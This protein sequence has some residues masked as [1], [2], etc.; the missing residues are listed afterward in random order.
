MMEVRPLGTRAAG[1]RPAVLVAQTEHQFEELALLAAQLAYLGVP[2]E[3]VVPE[4]PRR[5]LMR[6]RPAVRRHRRTLGL[7]DETGR[8]AGRPFPAEEL[9]A[10]AGVVLVMNDWG[11][12]RGL[13]LEA[14]RLGIPTA[15][16]VEG[17]QDFEDVDTGRRRNPY[18][19]ADLVLCLGQYDHDALSGTDRV[20]VGSERLRRLWEREASP[21]PVVPQAAINANFSYG[22]QTE[23]R[24]TWVRGAL[25][26]A[27]EAGVVSVLTRHPADR[28]L[29]GASR[30]SDHSALEVLEESTV[31]VSRF[32][33]LV[34]ESLLLGVATVYHNPHGEGAATF[35]DPIGGFA[36]TRDIRELTEQLRT[37]PQSRSE[38]R[39]EASGFLRKH[40]LL[41]SD[42]RP[43]VLASREIEKL[44]GES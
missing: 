33:T 30:V 19:S 26:A 9:L 8:T 3:L 37:P 41:E 44:R 12:P 17:V 20:I 24:R 29:T 21:I 36:V 35:A 7:V 40:L 6:Y 31:L 14:Q 15:A 34:Y 27:N 38:I 11:V 42:E 1:P 23:H 16:W 25:R 10:S 18:R 32:S 22:I 43:V 39:R 13:V 28:G 5:P 2:V 4:P